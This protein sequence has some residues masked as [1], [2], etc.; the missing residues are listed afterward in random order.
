M[1]K[2]HRRQH[3]AREHVLNRPRPIVSKINRLA[4][5]L[6]QAFVFWGLLCLPRQGISETIYAFG[7]G[8]DSCSSFISHI[9]VSPGRSFS[10]TAPDDGQKY[11]SKST[12]YL[13]WLL[14]FV[15]GYNAVMSDPAKQV[16]IDASAVDLYVR[17]WCTQNPTSNIF[18]AIRQFLNRTDP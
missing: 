8:T 11:Y 12:T 1:P 3:V 7:V 16:Q 17:G 5:G 10:R 18:T 4:G 15:T 14:G 9:A 6:V 2:R 13:E